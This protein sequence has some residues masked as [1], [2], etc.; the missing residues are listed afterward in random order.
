MKTEGKSVLI[1][2]QEIQRRV[3]DMG[4][5]ISRD[6]AGQSL[7]IVGVLK[8]SFI[9]IAD[10]I[11]QIDP[12]VLVDVEF[13]TVSSYRDGT[14]STGEVRIERDVET[15]L[16]GKN[17][18]LVEDIVDSGL[19]LNAVKDLLMS[20]RPRSLRIATLIEKEVNHRLP[21]SLDYV[22]FKIPDVFII[23]YGLDFAQRYR[24][25]KEIRVLDA[26]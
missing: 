16:E 17:V 14:V 3:A 9:F 2:E 8:G 4:A 24:N 22:G 23:G 11:R 7:T 26:S 21:A 20:R 12:T 18:L 5:D 6:Y 10:L 19:T 13:M 25:L 15:P 1:S